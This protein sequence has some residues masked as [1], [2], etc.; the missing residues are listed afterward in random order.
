MSL[1]VISYNV[2]GIRARELA[3]QQLVDEQ[4]PDIIGLQETKVEDALFPQEHWQ[5]QGY[6]T[7]FFGQKGHYGVALLSKLPMRQIVHGVE[8]G[9]DHQKRLIGASIDTDFGEVTIY[10]GYFPQGEGRDHPT[11]FPEK[12]AFYQNLLQLLKQRHQADHQTN[13]KVMVMGDFNI[14]YEDIDI[15]IGADNQKRWLRDGKSC[16]LPEERQWYQQLVE[17]GLSDAY[18]SLNPQ[19][20]HYSWFDYRSGGF[21][22]EPKRGLRIDHQLVSPALLEHCQSAQILSHYRGLERPSDH[23]PIEVVLG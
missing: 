7:E 3:L 23:C 12:Q 10:N 21:L 19:K 16:F 22:K 13:H 18:R 2:N 17:W 11:K 8:D 9:Q 20:E 4:Q 14:A 6:Q 1:K 15:G 5:N